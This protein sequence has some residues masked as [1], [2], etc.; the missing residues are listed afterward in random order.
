MNDSISKLIYVLGATQS[1]CTKIINRYKKKENSA[2]SC[3]SEGTGAADRITWIDNRRPSA[4]TPFS[5]KWESCAPDDEETSFLPEGVLHKLPSPTA[6]GPDQ[7]GGSMRPGR[8][9]SAV[10][11]TVLSPVLTTMGPASAPPSN[12][13]RLD[14]IKNEEKCKILKKHNEI[15]YSLEIERETELYNAKCG[16]YLATLPDANRKKKFEKKKEEIQKK[17]L[18]K[19]LDIGRNKQCKK[20][21]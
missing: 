19:A 4:V 18:K 7:D 2:N 17:Y 5:W 12:R 10:T 8:G 6:A 3:K 15:L 9:R 1:E 14:A 20:S 11:P 13:D 21:S 16:Q